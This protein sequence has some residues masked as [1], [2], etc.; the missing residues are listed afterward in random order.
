[1]S[2][3][4]TPY[5]IRGIAHSSHCGGKLIVAAAERFSPITNLMLV[6]HAYPWTIRRASVFEIVRHWFNFPSLHSSSVGTDKCLLFRA[7][8]IF[9]ILCI[10]LYRLYRLSAGRW[11]AKP[12]RIGDWQ[13]R[14]EGISRKP[15]GT[16]PSAR[17][18][19]P[20]K[21]NWSS[22]SECAANQPNGPNKP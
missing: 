15:T 14:T 1:M 6:V 20:V 17:G 10:V 21:K 22:G 16:S 5:R 11:T 3:N 4:F 2:V 7:D 18:T 9:C 12:R 19:S 8:F 13:T